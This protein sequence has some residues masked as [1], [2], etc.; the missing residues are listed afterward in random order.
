MDPI[1]SLFSIE[2]ALLFLSILINA[3][4]FLDYIEKRLA[5]KSKERRKRK[6]LTRK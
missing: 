3:G 2:D 4:I 5:K 1:Y 6:C